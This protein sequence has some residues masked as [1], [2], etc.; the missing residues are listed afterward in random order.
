[1]KALFDK[2][3]GI[4]IPFAE[5]EARDL[6][7]G[8][9]AYLKK[10]YYII[11]YVTE[12]H[13]QINLLAQEKENL[14]SIVSTQT[15]EIEFLKEEVEMHVRNKTNFERMS[16]EFSELTFG[17]EKIF[18]ILGGNEFVLD[19]NSA[20]LVELLPVLEKQA[21]ILVS[22]AENSKSKAQELGTKLLESQKVVDELTAKV[23]FLED[24]VQGGTVQPEIVQE[25]S[26]FEAPSLPTA[27]EISEI[28][29]VVRISIS[30][31]FS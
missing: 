30:I 29:D 5:S 1:M 12:L 27:S 24:S 8:S 22:E 10:L 16:I 3:S 4:D 13:P 21:M 28:E 17:L 26:I 6:D 14:Q 20:G 9:S 2:I 15:T 18:D 23:K 31:I 25:R 11:D 7:P 19:K